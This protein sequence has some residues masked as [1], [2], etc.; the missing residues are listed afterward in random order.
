MIGPHGLVRSSCVPPGLPPPPQSLPNGVENRYRR[1]GQQVTNRRPARA[2]HE[3]A[4]VPRLV[5][6]SDSPCVRCSTGLRVAAS[7]VHHSRMRSEQV[8]SSGSRMPAYHVMLRDV[9][10]GVAA[11]VIAAL[12]DVVLY[13]GGEPVGRVLVMAVACGALGVL[14]TDRRAVAITVVFAATVFVVV[15][16]SHVV[17]GQAVPYTPVLALAAMLGVGYRWLAAVEQCRR[18]A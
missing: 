6:T 14:L 8:P 12:L 7:Q 9:V 16:A 3:R 17:T 13:P 15:L 10:I 4:A 2:L 18:D 11:V 5:E 1:P